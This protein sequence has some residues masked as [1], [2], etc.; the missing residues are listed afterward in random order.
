M[1]KFYAFAA[2]AVA[3]LS[4]NAT[5]YVVGSGEGLTWDLPG[6]PVTAG[7]DGNYQFTVNGL[8]MLKFAT[9]ETT[10]WDVFNEQAYASG[11]ETFDEGVL[12]AGGQ[13]LP[14]VS[15]GDNQEFP[16]KGDYTITIT[17]GAD[18][19]PSTIT[20]YTTTPKPE[21]AAPVFV[22]GEMNGWG[23][24]EAWQFTYD[25]KDEAYYFVCEDETKIEAYQQFKFAD[26][27]WG[28]INYGLGGDFDGQPLLIDAYE[29]T[30]LVYN[31][32]NMIVEED[33]EGRIQLYIT[34]PKEAAVIM[35][36]EAGVKSVAIDNNLPVEY[37]NLQGVRVE[38]P[39]NGLFIA[40]QGKTV[41]KVVK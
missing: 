8:T 2:A 14:L 16:W 38:N 35:N 21:G 5:I 31:A 20:A 26:A 12:A 24:E 41:T 1:K 32:K 40:R 33:F 29:A 17:M 18:G 4:M 25:E 27:D 6:N 22:R 19:I 39:E 37:F 34:G 28:N 13:T 3:A 23:A 15:W 11:E 7:A 36:N 9:V 10:D 30:P